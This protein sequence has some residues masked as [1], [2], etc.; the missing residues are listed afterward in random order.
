MFKFQTK[1]GHVH[2]AMA[3]FELGVRSRTHRPDF[4]RRKFE[5]H[6]EKINDEL[7]DNNFYVYRDARNFILFLL[8]GQSIPDKKSK[9][10]LQLYI[11]I[12][13]S[14]FYYICDSSRNYY[15]YMNFS[16]ILM[17]VFWTRCEG[18]IDYT[19]IEG[20]SRS[21]NLFSLIFFKLIYHSKK[22]RPRYHSGSTFF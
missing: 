2:V 8:S 4:P 20:G 22:V 15:N 6:L 10:G 19:R 14:A 16:F 18:R 1:H 12:I 17:Y 3:P 11:F 21:P 13:L 5:T 9:A 7:K